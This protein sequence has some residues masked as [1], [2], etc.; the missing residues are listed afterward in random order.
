[1]GKPRY[2]HVRVAAP[3][4]EAAKQLRNEYKAMGIVLSMEEAVYRAKEK[5]K[6]INQSLPVN[7]GFNLK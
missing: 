6:K 4:F 5:S 3:V 2:N 1:M 7:W